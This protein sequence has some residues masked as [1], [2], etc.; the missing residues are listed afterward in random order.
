MKSL[1][2]CPRS[3]YEATSKKIE[4]EKKTLKQRYQDELEW[5]KQCV[6]ERLEAAQKERDK[7]LEYLDELVKK[8]KEA[9]EDEDY[10]LRMERLQSKLAYEMDE[11]NRRALE[12]EIAALQKEMDD[13]EFERDIENR[14][15]ELEKDNERQEL[16]AENQV[17]SLTK[18]F[19]EKMTDANLTNEVLKTIDMEEFALTGAEMGEAM[20]GSMLEALRP[21]AAAIDELVRKAAGLKGATVTQNITTDNSTNVNVTTTGDVNSDQVMRDVN[22]E[23]YLEGIK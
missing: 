16:W 14:R 4:E 17:E 5:N 10:A 2:I 9:R 3:F 19:E 21:V 7:E 11:D 22:T 18:E 12:K 6:N 13:T 15:A 1:A 8:R 23:L 20:A